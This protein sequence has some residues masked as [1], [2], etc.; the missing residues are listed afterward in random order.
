VNCDDG[1]R[2]TWRAKSNFRPGRSSRRKERHLGDH[3]ASFGLTIIRFM[4]SGDMPPET[5]PEL[6]KKKKRSLRLES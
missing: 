5:M 6:R 4:N 3:P 1:Q 2:R